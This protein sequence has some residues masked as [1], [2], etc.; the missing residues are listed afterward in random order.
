MLTSTSMKL[1]RR[2]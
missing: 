1:E 2:I